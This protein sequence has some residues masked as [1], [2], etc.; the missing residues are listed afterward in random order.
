MTNDQYCWYNLLGGIFGQAK[1]D[2]FGKIERLI[3]NE[4]KQN[5]ISARKVKQLIIDY[6]TRIKKEISEYLY[7]EY[8]NYPEGEYI[9]AELNRQRV[10]RQISKTI[11]NEYYKK[12]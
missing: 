1:K 12:V 3:E 8:E 5:L 9:T 11:L 10:A 2:D 7:K 6:K 4:L